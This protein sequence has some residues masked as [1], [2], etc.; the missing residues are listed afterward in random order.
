MHIFKT[1]NLFSINLIT[2]LELQIDVDLRGVLHDMKWM[3]FHGLLDFMSSSHFN[4]LHSFVEEHF[5]L[6]LEVPCVLK[7]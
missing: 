7:I 4:K 1:T 5:A 6:E 3:V 2:E